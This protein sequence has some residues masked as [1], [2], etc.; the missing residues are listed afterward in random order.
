MASGF[1]GSWFGRPAA[2]RKASRTARLISIEA[3][4]R[5][6]WTPRDMS[7]LAREGYMRNA[8]VH[9]CVRMVAESA[10][11]VPLLLMRQREELTSHP[12]LDLLTRPN[13]R[14]SGAA[15]MEAVFSHLL[16]AG[17]AYLEAVTVEG[18][19]KEIFALRPDRMKVIPGVNGWPAAFD[20][21]VGGRVVRLAQ[22]EEG[23]TPVLHLALFHPLDDHYGLSPL[24]AAATAVDT[25]NAAAA[26]HKALLD[27]AARPSGALVYDGPD[28][29]ALGQDQFERLK[30]ELEESFQGAA[31]AGRPLLLEG[32]LDWKPMALAPKELDFIEARNAAAREVALAFGVP[33]LLLGLPGDNTFSNYLEANRAF[34]RSTVLPL[35]H[36]TM[37]SLCAWLEP[38]FGEGL[39]LE[40]DL[41]RIEALSVE[42]EALWRRVSGADFL[43]RDEKRQAVGYGRA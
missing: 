17:N 31:N 43:D 19:I 5:P 33:P 20:Y 36:R 15:F 42:R 2:E 28:G 6:V 10:A 41:D 9:R 25:H 11:A 24:E 14:Q 26:W 29:A 37:Q 27:N 39:R 18:E 1:L 12:L 21:E 40:P 22:A 38:S 23:Q 35:I 7:A 16:I 8:V 30:S 13:P 3:L 4:G 34:I 32:G